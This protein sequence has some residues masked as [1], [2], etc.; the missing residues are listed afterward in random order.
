MGPKDMKKLSKNRQM[1]LVVLLIIGLGISDSVAR[2]SPSQNSQ[3]GD[4][5]LLTPQP[6]TVDQVTHNVG[7]I[8]TTVDNWGYIGGYWFYGLPSGE[9]PRGSG[10]NY[11]GEILYWFGAVNSVGD[12]VVADAYEDFQGLPTDTT[13]ANQY[14]ILLST[15]TSRFLNYDPND[16][17]GAGLGNPARGWRVWDPTINAFTYNQ[18]YN[19]LSASYFPGGPTSLQESHYRFSDNAGGTPLLGLEMTQT[20]MQWNYCYNEDFM[21]VVVEVTNNSSF[22]YNNFIFSVYVDIDVGGPADDGENGRLGDYVAIDTAVN[23]A[24]TYDFY[25]FDPGW[26][27][28]E[29]TGYMGTLILETPDDIGITG[30]F[31]DDWSF[32][33]QNDQGRYDAINSA[34]IMPSHPPTDQVYVVCTRGI[35]LTAGRT[36][37][38]VYAIVAGQTEQELRDNATLAEELYT[39]NYVGPTPPTA[40]NLEY[41]AGDNKAYLF[42]NDTAEYSIDP[43]S[44]VQDFQ[45]YKLY[46]SD[47]QG[48]T[49]GITDYTPSSSC[50]SI[51]YKTVAHYSVFNPGDPIQHSFI[52]TGLYNGVEYWY[53]L[54]AF[55]KGDTIL[56]IDPLQ[57]GFGSPQVNPHIVAV[58]PSPDPAGYY[59]ASTTSAHS[60]VG[61][62]LPSDGSIYPQVFDPAALTGTDFRVVFEE[63]PEKTYWHVINEANGD[64]VLAR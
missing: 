40:P 20:I 61:P 44:G 60:Y 35:N 31:T 46:R 2:P 1:A 14:S 39:A 57:S 58:R 9:W 38:Y 42:W 3:G 7:N 43:F 24:W 13:A 32:I 12:T 8:A 17:V 64:T 37:R 18:L 47:N 53:C 41:R 62:Y 4:Q 34:G 50:L 10:H 33:P 45:G 11:I 6:Y 15:D 59:D 51:D 5:P 28:T 54:A 49:W 25:G 16:T 29:P 26:G 56:G 21:Y 19:N 22:D 27:P 63:A 36:I 23:L 52:D 30:F 55:D 48:K